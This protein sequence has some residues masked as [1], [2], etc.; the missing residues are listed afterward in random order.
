MA[1]LYGGSASGRL[2]TMADVAN[3][4]G[5][6]RQLVSIVFR[7]GSGVNPETEARIRSAAKEIGYR[8]N[9][10]ARSLRQDSSMYI[11]VVF[12][13]SESSMD[14]LLPALYK[15][16]EEA[17]YKLVLSAVS[18]LR[19]ESEAIDEVLGHRCQGIVL[20]SPQLPKS[21]LQILAREIPMVS[22]GRRTAGI[23]WGMV[24]SW[25][26][27]GVAEA[28][29]HLIA[30]GHSEISC[31]YAKNMND[32]EYRLEGYLTAMDAAGLKP[33]VLELE[34]DFAE[35]GGARA[36]DLLLARKRL[37]TA[38]ICN[39]DQSAFGLTHRLQAEGVRY[40]EDISVVGYDDTLAK[41]PFLDFTSV[42]QEGD[43]LAQAAIF[44]LAARIRGEKFQSETVLT[45]TRL[46]AR[47]STA[48]PSR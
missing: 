13:T 27:R 4:V 9:L 25:G 43:E 30:L 16:A 42:R 11:G 32:G 10:A 31:I 1:K 39:N 21:R 3:K 12:H 23:R 17:G 36:A 15:H 41:W 2:P 45:S 37:P 47:S 38:V 35:L 6:S 5:V 20:I 48:A 34:G 24:S 18:S 26:E 29:N 46:I 8:P 7:G 14:E 19:S 40:P 28:V 22:I 33:D 44:D